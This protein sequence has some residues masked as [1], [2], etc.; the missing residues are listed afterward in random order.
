MS[1]WSDLKDL[2][3]FCTIENFRRNTPQQLQNLW[4]APWNPTMV[5]RS[6]GT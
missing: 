6:I 2:V 3:M 4:R 5:L 1:N